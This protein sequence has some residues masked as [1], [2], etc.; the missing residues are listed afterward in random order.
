[1]RGRASKES[2]WQPLCSNYGAAAPARGRPRVGS[3]AAAPLPK[4]TRPG[5]CLGKSSCRGG[6]RPARN[7]P[8]STTANR[9]AL[10]SERP[11]VSS[12]GGFTGWEGLDV[13]H[14]TYRPVEGFVVHC[15]YRLVEGFVVRCT[16]RPVEGFVIRCMYRPVEG[17]VICC[18]YRLVEGLL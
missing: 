11:R 6:V 7:C 3:A 2:S 1:M 15:T 14:C 18:T 10:L 13:V 17:F 16:Y 12:L 4:S 8:S 5:L 9:M